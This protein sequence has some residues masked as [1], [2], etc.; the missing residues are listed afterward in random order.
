MI[1]SEVIQG[2]VGKKDVGILTKKILIF[3]LP[4]MFQT[5]PYFKV[6]IYAFLYS[7]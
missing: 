3:L 1:K 7:L 5:L 2:K 6:F 4:Q